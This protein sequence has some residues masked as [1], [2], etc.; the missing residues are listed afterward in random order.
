[1]PLN[2]SR[3][4]ENITLTDHQWEDA[5]TKYEGVC[6]CLDRHFYK[7][8]YVPSHKFLFGSYKLKTCIRPVV[9]DQDVDVLFKITEAQYEKYR[10]NPGGLLQEVRMAIKDKYTTTD[11]IKA[12]GKVVLVQ[13][14]DGTHNV[15]VLPALER[16]DMTFLIPNTE[17]GGSWEM[18]NPRASIAKFQASN[19]NTENLTCELTKIIKSWVRNT[20]T[21]NYKSYMVTDDVIHF[22]N[23]IYPSGRGENTWLAV[24]K[25]F[26]TYRFV[27][28]SN[29][30]DRYSHIDTAKCRADKAYQY[31]E[32]GKYIEASRELRKIFGDVF[33]LADCNEDVS[34]NEEHFIS[35]P[36]PW[37]VG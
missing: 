18:F 31:N 4:M 5:Q 26:F 15:E 23:N 37:R 19:Q 7:S 22:V 20:E 27:R 10:N 29:D 34:M 36:S 3:F 1:M 2:F 16:S 21:L 11:K 17:N 14:A 33:P 28:M 35:A 13:F 32:D 25:N 24:I 6:K 8:D 9:P 12:W 30:D